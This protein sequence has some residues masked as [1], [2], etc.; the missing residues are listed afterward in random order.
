MYVTGLV[1]LV[2][3]QIDVFTNIVS[4]L[5]G[6]LYTFLEPVPVLF[7]ALENNAPKSS[8]LHARHATPENLCFAR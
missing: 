2:L 6:G 4:M 1:S 5:T 8:P 7:T 3:K